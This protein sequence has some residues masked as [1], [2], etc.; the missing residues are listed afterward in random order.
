MSDLLLPAYRQLRPAERA[1]VDAYV[2]HVGALAAQAGCSAVDYV[3]A[4]RPIVFEDNAGLLSR[5]LVRAA[6]ADRIRELSETL[7]V[8]AHKLLSE[9][10]GI[11]ASSMAHYF[12]ADGTGTVSP[13]FDVVTP[14]QWAA[15][16]SLDYEEDRFGGRKIKIRLHSKLDA[17]EKLMKYMGMYEKDNRQKVSDQPQRTLTADQSVESVADVYAQSLRTR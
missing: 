17:I 13:N 14:E 16:S 6:I 11:A 8:N 3:A 5:G 7:A 1:F 12:E 9:V 15:V 4:D 2:K 10:A